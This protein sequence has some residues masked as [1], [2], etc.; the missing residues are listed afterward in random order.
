MKVRQHIPG[1]VDSRPVIAEVKTQAELL[2]LP[3]IHRWSEE[4]PYIVHS[5]FHRFSVHRNY[6]G[7]ASTWPGDGRTDQLHLLLAEF[8]EGREWWVVANLSGEDSLQI[9]EGLPEWEPKD[10]LSADN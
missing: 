2:A 9:L 8:R 4:S 7:N 6:W 10:K 1:F 5:P 3:F